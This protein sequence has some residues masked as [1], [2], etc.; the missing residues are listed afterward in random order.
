MIGQQL[1]QAAV[2]KCECDPLCE[3][4]D[5]YVALM[6]K[7]TEDGNYEIVNLPSKLKKRNADESPN[8]NYQQNE[9]EDDEMGETAKQHEAPKQ[10]E[11]P[12]QH[13]APNQNDRIEIVGASSFF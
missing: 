7:E 13:E 3:G 1:A 5:D 6:F 4:G 12:K 10:Y 2:N 8:Q 11:A 9:K